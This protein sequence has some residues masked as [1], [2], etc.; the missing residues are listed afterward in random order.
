MSI[1]NILVKLEKYNI[2]LKV[3]GEKI[4]LGGHKKNLTQDFINEIKDN[5]QEIIDYFNS[6]ST[7]KMNS[8]P[9]SF[10]QKRLWFL[11]QMQPDSVAYNVVMPVKL[12]GK[13][14]AQLL[15]DS[16]NVLIDRQK[17]FKTAFIKVDSEPIQIIKEDT[18]VNLIS[19]D[20][21]N[22]SSSD[23]EDEIT[24]IILEELNE[25]FDLSKGSLLRCTFIHVKENENIFIA[26][27]NHFAVDGW[28]IGLFYDE[29][30]II[31][32]SLME[33]QK[34]S[35]PDIPMQ[36]IEYSVLEQ[37]LLR[38]DLLQKQLNYW[39]EKLKDAEFVLNLPIDKPRLAIQTYNGSRVC[40]SID[41][42]HVIKLNELGKKTQTTLFMLL[43]AAFQL[44]LYYYTLQKDLIVATAISNRSSK[45]VENL[46]GPF[47]NNLL[48]RAKFEDGNMT[49]QNFLSQVKE[50]VIG[51]FVNKDLPFE[52]L[53]E[54][55]KPERDFS[56]NPLFQV[57]FTLQNMHKEKRNLDNIIMEQLDV[58]NN[59]SKFDLTLE[60][61][62]EGEKISGWLEYN[63]DLFEK[64][65][66]DRMV[67]YYQNILEAIATGKE[68]KLS[69]IIKLNDKDK[70]LILGDWNETEMDYPSMCIHEI[71]EAQAKNSPNIYALI[72]N[73]KKITYCELDE[74]SNQIL[75]YLIKKGVKK[76]ERIAIYMN[77]SIDMIA[78]I[79][80]VLKA[81]CI[82]VPMGKDYPKERL[83]FM[84]DDSEIKFLVIDEDIKADDL[85][86]DN[87]INIINC[88]NEIKKEGK[89]SIESKTKIDDA[90]Y[91]IYTSGSTGRPKGVLGTH[92]GIINRLNW[93]WREY[94]YTED[95]IC[96]QKTA[97][98]F[99]DSITEMFSP[100]L[101]GISLVIIPK[102][103]LLDMKKF[104][105]I[106]SRNNIT[107]IVL[108]P[109]LLRALLEEENV[110]NKLKNL[111]V[112][113]TSGEALNIDLAKKFQNKFTNAKIINLY[114]SSEVSGDV[115]YYE[116]NKETKCFVPIGKPVDNT[117]IYILDENKTPVPIGVTGEI[118]VAGEG[119]AKGYYG[120][121]DLTK[122]RFVKNNIHPKKYSN[123]FKT[124]DLGRYLSDGTI[125]YCGRKDS[126]LKIR[127]I[128]VETDEIKNVLLEFSYINDAIIVNQSSTKDEVRLVAY[129][130]LNKEIKELEIKKDLSEKVPNYMIPSEIIVLDKIPLLPN[131]KIDKKN[132]LKILL[133][134][135]DVK[136]ETPS[137]PILEIVIGIFEDIMKIEN[138]SPEDNFFELGGHSLIMTQVISRIRKI[139]N[140]DVTLQE[141]FKNLTTYSLATLIEEKLKDSD[142]SEYSE[143]Q[144][145]PRSE[146][147]PL[148]MVQK[149]LWFLQQLEPDSIEYNIPMA[150]E[151]KGNLKI[152]ELRKS[153][154]CIVGRHEILKSNYMQVDG[155][156]VININPQQDVKLQVME[157]SNEFENAMQYIREQANL[158]FDLEKGLLYRISL[159]KIDEQRYILL[160]CLHH[161]ISD[162]WSRNIILKELLAFY[163]N[164]CKGTPLNTLRELKIQYIDYAIWQNKQ[165]KMKAMEKQLNYWRKKLSGAI[166]NFTFNPSEK[167]K[168]YGKSKCNT[169]EFD[170][171][172]RLTSLVKGLAR[173][174]GSTL[175]MVLLSIYQIMIYFYTGVEEIYVGS[176]I[177]GR[178]KS[179]TEGLIGFFVNT[180]VL[181]GELSCNTN[182]LLF[183]Q[184]IKK[185]ALEAYENQE[186]PFDKV[187]EVI[188]PERVVN[189]N[190]IFQVM[191]ILQNVPIE[192]IKFGDISVMPI[193]LGNAESK[194]DLTLELVDEGNRI[195]GWFQYNV[196][197]FNEETV[198]RM[199][200]HYKN[201]LSCIIKNRN[202]DISNISIIDSEEKQF[203][204]EKWNNTESKHS[205]KC[206][207]EIFEEQ[208]KDTPNSCALIDENS[209]CTY[210][211][212]DDYSNKI[213][214]YLIKSGAQIGDRIAICMNR[215]IDMVASILA[216][217]KTGG[218]YVPVAIDYPNERIKFM[219]NDSE[220]RY[221][222]VKE[223]FEKENQVCGVNVIDI[224]QCKFEIEQ[225]DATKP[226]R[227]VT[228]DD[229][230]YIIYTSGSTGKPKG[231]IGIHKGIVNRCSWMWRVY[232]Y[233]KDE[234]CCQK[235]SISF[236]DSIIEIFMPLLKG[237]ELLIIPQEDLLDIEKFSCKLSEYKISRIV[238][239]PSF[240]KVLLGEDNI[241]KK[242]EHLKICVTSGEV[243]STNL[244][245]EFKK[246]LPNTKLINIYGSSEVSADVTYYEVK[247]S[248]DSYIPVGKAIDNTEIYILNNQRKL[249]PAGIIGEI[250]VAGEGL[251]KGYWKREDLTKDKFIK[252]EIN[253]EKYPYMFKTGDV[254][255]YLHDGNIEYRGRIDNQVKI[256]GIRIETESVRNI[257]LDISEV[258]DAVVVSAKDFLGELKLVAYI[259]L[260]VPEKQIDIQSLKDILVLKMPNYM[261]PSE[262]VILDEIPFLLNGK[263]DK[264]KLP[265]PGFRSVN[266]SEKEK[267]CTNIEKEIASIWMELINVKVVYRN[268][269]FFN[270]GGHSLLATRLLS[271]LRA[272]FNVE[273]ELR[274]FYDNATIEHIGKII[275]N[276]ILQSV[277]VKDLEEMSSYIDSLNEKQIEEMLQN[278]IN[279]IN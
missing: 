196:D 195:S 29:L 263:L 141:F 224:N 116:L 19:V 26:I 161:I 41:S 66:I 194:F 37:K 173:E 55:L 198:K 178:T 271:R 148:S 106:L 206:V 163:N 13:I 209:S 181:K 65:T 1:D 144:I 4:V 78:A 64:E 199:V 127:G 146:N 166:D 270:L 22:F 279:F 208:A 135:K 100:L 70:K 276:K 215:S 105:S 11:E 150:V 50:T 133:K 232:P 145:E 114:G 79:L 75:R 205:N 244:A 117:D 7:M 246:K 171:D 260:E 108:V 42:E 154:E 225:E 137:N 39:Q 265:S 172:Q 253:Q 122:E 249:L 277:D 81:G 113:V 267:L 140:I 228:N 202:I 278:D 111:K 80:A 231:V 152:E 138:I 139:F 155:Q 45:E 264:S 200:K 56:R 136:T 52:I 129:I 46:I 60:L 221:V 167:E 118:Y 123:M 27:T 58:D 201:I 48:L 28:S 273:L 237:I 8:Y 192:E 179:E 32:K 175:F 17:I 239:V 251:A 189:Q 88:K 3:E 18:K 158:P 252:N 49:V 92:K 33:N 30:F 131:G 57:L 156:P 240:L 262:F 10:L 73:D 188:N 212:L 35:L 96:C 230:A 40:F 23:K 149:R 83:I 6:N 107:R 34:N 213:A 227:G 256:R 61:V 25:P 109:S 214:H 203:L 235:T 63:V 160:I 180:L 72:E 218:I 241:G 82:Y 31:Y 269:N 257:I 168:I 14:N 258:K 193:Q 142:I 226:D 120:N 99:V 229:A 247:E 147:M 86:V 43:L 68:K 233:E 62:D 191:F 169:V 143:I 91:L 130:V 110:E 53:V 90:A 9:L 162:G 159:A 2:D 103:D 74:Y 134:K 184:Q 47:S 220:S 238:L 94:P 250:Y 128:R 211:Q 185:D 84:K 77:R 177:A 275:E 76:E 112:C 36:Y 95:E 243:L 125:E 69:E 5:K 204:L 217:L 255:R 170:L 38:E 186:V 102:E 132:I 115:T 248:S 164:L 12:R 93:M 190:P 268:D 67:D 59:T 24:R 121:E 174:E 104:I 223:S 274:D 54:K 242:L 219:L 44:L 153:F 176:P 236:V 165:F 126:Q 16:I 259:V 234:V 254:G 85:Q 210:K 261:I 51:A 245:N 20:V 119:L 89:S 216:V 272:K 182:Y 157:F 207:H 98:S 101:K 124:G 15:Q 71:F 21:S 87:T 97:I 187:V 266:S 197:M 151:I 222:I 183:L